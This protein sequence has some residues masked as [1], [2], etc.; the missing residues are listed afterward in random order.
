MG[1]VGA[2]DQPAARQAAHL[3][4]DSLPVKN[5]GHAGHGLGLADVDA[6]DDRVGVR[7]AH[8][9]GIALVREVHVV[10]VL[11]AAGQKAIVL[12][13]ADRLA[14]VRQVGKI[15]CTHVV[16]SLAGSAMNRVR[17]RRPWRRRPAARP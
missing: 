6:L 1:A 5:L 17:V 4:F 14:D 13:A 3:A 7:R 10:G 16:Y 11:A 2:G 9:H 15:G 12:L 8:E